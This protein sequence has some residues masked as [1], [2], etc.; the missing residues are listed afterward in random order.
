E[1]FSTST[2]GHPVNVFSR[3]GN[4]GTGEIPFF[5]CASVLAAFSSGPASAQ[6]VVADRRPTAAGTNFASRSSI[7]VRSVFVSRTCADET[8][9]AGPSAPV[10]LTFSFFGLGMARINPAATPPAASARAIQKARRR[11][12]GEWMRRDTIRGYRWV[13]RTRFREDRAGDPGR[14]TRRAG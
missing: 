2:V 11:M 14:T 5:H 9:S 1:F 4:A 10:G 3:T 13:R 6:A 7:D 8:V 12:R